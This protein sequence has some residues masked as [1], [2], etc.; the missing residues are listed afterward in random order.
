M[1]SNPSVTRPCKLLRR[2]SSGF[3]RRG[4][5]PSSHSATLSYISKVSDVVWFEI[6]L[7]SDISEVQSLVL[8]CRF[9]HNI[10]SVRVFWLYR[11]HA[12]EQDNAPNLPPHISISTLTLPQLRTLVIRAHRRHRNCMRPGTLRPTREIRVNIKCPYLHD[13]SSNQA[14]L[15]GGELFLVW[16]AEGY[17][18]C[19]NVRK[20]KCI[21]TYQPKEPMSREEILE[22]QPY[23]LKVEGFDYD[24]Q[25][26][27]DVHVLVVSGVSSPRGIGTRIIEIIQSSPQTK[28]PRPRYTYKRENIWNVDILTVLAKLSGGVLA[29]CMDDRLLLTFWEENRSVLIR[30]SEFESID[31]TD[32]HL[33]CTQ[34]GSRRE[35][36]VA[37]RLSSLY[38]KLR[39]LNATR[40][41]VKSL[42]LNDLPHARCPITP[43]P[44]WLVKNTVVSI[45]NFHWKPE[46]ERKAR[47]INITVSQTGKD[48][49]TSRIFLQVDSFHLDEALLLDGGIP[50]LTHH[51]HWLT[52]LDPQINWYCTSMPP[53]Q[54]GQI[55]I[56]CYSSNGFSLKLATTSYEDGMVLKE[57]PMLSIICNMKFYSG[58]LYFLT[59]DFASLVIQYFD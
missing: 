26:N 7:Y 24:M 5:Q 3:R 9:I 51:K 30:G 40:N 29:V 56:H 27:G 21:W 23:K 43:N 17:I 54:A 20:R 4:H 50:Q 19:F 42:T 1:P 59:S 44:D 39:D 55:L 13:I 10:I 12:L 36:V 47:G 2:I 37:I 53:S 46:A 18:Q 41:S 57:L 34:Y 35:S 16:T 25:A 33:I 32:N 14:L 52:G 15:P 11:L 49:N 28:I 22:R 38:K 8:T 31:L 45:C 58:A 48:L 6:A